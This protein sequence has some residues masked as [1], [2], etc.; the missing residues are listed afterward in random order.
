[1]QTEPG[2]LGGFAL[3]RTVRYTVFV[4]VRERI[5]EAFCK[6]QRTDRD[7]NL[8]TLRRI[9]ESEFAR[10]PAPDTVAGVMSAVRR[11]GWQR[12]PPAV[13]R[14]R[15]RALAKRPRPSRRKRDQVAL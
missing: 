9:L 1:M 10:T 6:W 15:M 11:R 4:T 3:Y 5:V 14:E 7:R 12:V 8:D 13:R 2:H